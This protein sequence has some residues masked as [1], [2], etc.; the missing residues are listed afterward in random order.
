MKTKSLSFIG[1]FLFFIAYLTT[2]QAQEFW[3]TTTSGGVNDTGIIFE[4]GVANPGFFNTNFEF[5]NVSSGPSHSG[6]SPESGLILASN[7]NLYGMTNSGGA[8]NYGTLFEYNPVTFTYTKKIDFGDNTDLNGRSPIG[9]LVEA[10]D[11]FYYGMTPLG[12]LGVDGVF[13]KFNPTTGTLLKIADFATINPTVGGQPWGSLIQASNGK[14]YGMT[15]D[16]LASIFEYDISSNTFKNLKTFSSADGTTPRGDLLQASNGKLYGITYSGGVNGKGT[17]FEYDIANSIFTK[18]KDFAT[19]IGANPEGSLIQANN[20]KLYGLTKFGG[21][22]DLGV[23]F[24]Y[25]ISTNTYIKKFDFDG[26]NHGENPRGRLIQ[27]S[28]DKFYGTTIGGGLNNLGTLFE[29]DLSTNILTKKQDMGSGGTGATVTGYL[30]TKYLIERSTSILGVSEVEKQ[31]GF[32]LYPNPTSAVIKM[33]YKSN[34]IISKIRLFNSIGSLVKEFKATQTELNISKL[35]IGLYILKI[36]T[37]KGSISKK[38]I[39]E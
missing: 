31:F 28:N 39:K 37:N 21:L 7:G 6:R 34:L 4:W 23:L 9:A 27:A 15:T 25:D 10:S 32:K 22:N 38:I 8:N 33:Q 5:D 11:G 12:G 20:D 17:L 26:A 1:V 13:F 35:P 29:Y 3:G 16:V 24:E 18:L 14:L 19:G 36:E 30:P 2:I